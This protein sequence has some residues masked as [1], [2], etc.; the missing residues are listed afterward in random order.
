MCLREILTKTEFKKYAKIEKHSRIP[1]TYIGWKA[2][3]IRNQI[4]PLYYRQK[5]KLFPIAKWIDEKEFRM[6]MSCDDALI[7]VNTTRQY[8]TG[9]HIFPNLIA[10]LNFFAEHASIVGE[11][12][13]YTKIIKVYYKNA[14]VYGLQSGEPVIV[15]KDMYIPKQTPYNFD[16]KPSKK[17]LE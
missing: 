2:V 15:V 1:L 8:K 14:I 12:A 6:S 4:K 10:A 11:N 7:R 13:P 3:R 17:Y 5:G 9:F 16:G